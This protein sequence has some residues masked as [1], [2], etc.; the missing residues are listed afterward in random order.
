MTRTISITE[1]QNSG[2]ESWGVKDDSPRG[3][4]TAYTSEVK[5]GD[6]VVIDNHFT[7]VIVAEEPAQ[8]TT[9]TT[10]HET[11]PVD[12]IRAAIEAEPACRSKAQPLFEIISAGEFLDNDPGFMGTTYAVQT[13]ML[14]LNYVALNTWLDTTLTGDS[15]D[16]E[17]WAEWHP[18]EDRQTY[19][20]AIEKRRADLI[21]QIAAALQ[22]TG[23]TARNFSVVRVESEIFAVVYTH[24]VQ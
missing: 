12:H 22:I 13:Y 17:S 7:T 21:A 11:S 6:K 24:E 8:E 20:A 23:A 16:D 1:L 10:Q 3:I 14:R 15:V 19:R 5:P 9:E 4:H 18:D 2:V